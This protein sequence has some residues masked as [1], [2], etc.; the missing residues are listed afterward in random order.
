[1]DGYGFVNIGRIGWTD[2]DCGLQFGA[3]SSECYG[4]MNNDV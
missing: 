2:W 4:T 1:M 3:G